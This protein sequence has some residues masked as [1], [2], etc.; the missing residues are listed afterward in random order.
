[1]NALYTHA[2]RQTQSITAD[3]AL[4]EKSISRPGESSGRLNGQ[5]VASLAALQRTVEDYESM[6]KRELVEA[7]KAKAQTRVDRIKNDYKELR[8]QYDSLKQKQTSQRHEAERASLLSTSIAPGGHSGG[9]SAMQQRRNVPQSPSL[10]GNESPFSYSQRSTPEPSSSTRG[11]LS[12]G[13]GGLPSSSYGNRASTRNLYTP[14]TNAALDENSFINDTSNQLDAFIAH[15]QAILG[16]L[17][18]QRD[19]LKGTQRRLLSAANTMGLSRE[20]IGFIERRGR[21][22]MAVFLVGSVITLVSFIMIIRY[23]G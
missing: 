8:S 2:L 19:I 5:I 13:G 7:N 4:L 15:G 22:D 18:D 16:N 10:G 9:G 23:L 17:G 3:L 14:R 1:M 20:V 6:A 12:S 11:Y 21:G